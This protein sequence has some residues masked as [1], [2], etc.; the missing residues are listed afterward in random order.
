MPRQVGRPTDK[1]SRKNRAKFLKHLAQTGQ[2]TLASRMAGYDTT[3]WIYRL[4]QK[5]AEFA[6]AFEEAKHAAGDL[7]HDEVIRRGLHGI[8]KAVLYKGDVVHYEKEYSDSL[9]AMALKAVRPEFRD[10]IS[11]SGQIGVAVT[12]ALSVAVIPQTAPKLDD[13]ERAALENLQD[14]K[15]LAPTQELV[16]TLEDGV[17][18]MKPRDIVRR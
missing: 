8:D 11:V 17:V 12:G 14:Q 9:L 16:E 10:N 3:Q 7:L 2:I 1:A 15:L 13:W 6:K 4:I 5:D 18:V